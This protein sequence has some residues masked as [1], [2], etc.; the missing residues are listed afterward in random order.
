MDKLHPGIIN[1]IKA[2]L[3]YYEQVDVISYSI[4]I[5]LSNEGGDLI[6]KTTLDFW[7]AGRKRKRSS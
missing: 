7:R 1:A 3:D 4:A 6:T 5:F 2:F